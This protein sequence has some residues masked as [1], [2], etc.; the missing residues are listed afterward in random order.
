MSSSP[1]Q[2]KVDI[3]QPLPELNVLDIERMKDE[4]FWDYAR[5]RAHAIPEPLSHA[6]YLECRL[7]QTACLIALYDLAEVL[8]PPHRLARLP[9]MP[10]WMA[11]ITAWRGETIAVVDLGLYLPGKRQS[12]TSLAH[13]AM[14]LIACQD[15][16]I[17]G[18][19]VPAIGLTSTIEFEQ[20]M[21]PSVLHT[22]AFAE[23]TSIV[24]GMY[25]NIPVINIPTLLNQLVQQIG[26]TAK[27]G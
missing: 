16:Q 15:R 19:L 12:E 25:R 9:G 6:E 7:D 26:T 22:F 13:T 5:Q 20:I 14:L 21:P 23:K 4:E 8:S 11:G 3:Q 2:P 18:L 24:T 17:F 10:S 1:E 27:H